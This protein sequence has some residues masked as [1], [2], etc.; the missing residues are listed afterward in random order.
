MDDRTYFDARGYVVMK[1][2]LDP[3]RDLQPVID[4]YSVLADRI[5]GRLLEDGALASYDRDRPVLDRLHH[6]LAETGGSCFQHL[7]IS[8]PMDHIRDDTPV[9]LG[10]AIF[11]LIRNPH[12]LDAVSTLIG[13]EIYAN[14]VQHTRIKLPERHFARN[15]PYSLMGTTFWHQ[16]LGVISE[17][18]DRSDIVTAFIA[19]TA[20]TEDNGCVIVAP[21]S[22]K[23]GLVHHCRTLARNGIPDAAVGPWTPIIMD[24]G[25]VLFFHRAT[26]HASLPNL[27]EDLRWSF[28]L[29]YGPIG[30]PTGRR[31]FPGFVARSAAHPEQ[32]LTDHAAWV[33]SW[34]EARSQL[35]TMRE[36]P[37]FTRW[38]WDPSNPTR[39]CPVCA[40]H[41]PVA[42]IATAV[43]G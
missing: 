34:H 1:G 3:Q 14:P 15:A 35:A 39:E 29:R 9:H 20:S 11:D 42:A 2:L 17:E 22:H 31:W 18:A 32:E 36:L 41:A 43:S 8:L 21:G 7:D 19:V 10:R 23:G 33:R 27:G 16:D 40:T 12:L 6:L 37:K 26:Q 24:P 25:D 4:E 5:A 30:Q 13:P 38:P 28:D